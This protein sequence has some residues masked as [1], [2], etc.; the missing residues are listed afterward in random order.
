MFYK[1]VVC[2]VKVGNIGFRVHFKSHFRKK[3]N[4]EF[5][6]MMKFNFNKNAGIPSALHYTLV[7]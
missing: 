5:I 3:G 4:R 6:S 1:K 7:Y 2:L